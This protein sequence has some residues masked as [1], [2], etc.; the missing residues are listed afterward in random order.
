VFKELRRR[1]YS[2]EKSFGL[3]R[4]LSIE[5]KTP[6]ALLPITVR[7]LVPDDVEEILDI[8]DEMSGADC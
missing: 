1:A 4:D 7:P 3:V 8:S 2:S 6:D 5:F